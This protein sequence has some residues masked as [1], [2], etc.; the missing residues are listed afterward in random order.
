MEKGRKG[1][2]SCLDRNDSGVSDWKC[3]NILGMDEFWLDSRSSKRYHDSIYDRR[4]ILCISKYCRSRAALGFS[5]ADRL[6]VCPLPAIA[7]LDFLT[8]FD[9]THFVAMIPPEIP[10]GVFLYMRNGESLWK[11]GS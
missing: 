11:N 1:L 4:W 7:Y 10:T 5:D 9:Y 6:F 3:S 8:G 2:G